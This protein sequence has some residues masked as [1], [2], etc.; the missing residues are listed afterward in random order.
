MG[1]HIIRITTYQPTAPLSA[2]HSWTAT[3]D[4]IYRPEIKETKERTNSVTTAGL[5]ALA[6]AP[7]HLTRW[8]IPQG[9]IK[10]TYPTGNVLV[11]CMNAIRSPNRKKAETKR[12]LKLP[13]HPRL[14]KRA[15]PTFSPITIPGTPE[16]NYQP[17]DLKQLKTIKKKT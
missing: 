16:N 1:T 9:F 6:S 3:N 11:Q 17:K 13:I 14:A 5:K 15:R 8:D 7:S 2:S 4:P 12:V 10:Q